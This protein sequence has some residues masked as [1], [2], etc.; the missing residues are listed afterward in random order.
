MVAVIASGHSLHPHSRFDNK[1]TG[2]AARREGRREGGWCHWLLMHPKQ[3][4]ETRGIPNATAPSLRR[5]H[6]S[7]NL[8]AYHTPP[9]CFPLSCCVAKSCGW[10][11]K[12]F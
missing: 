4:D 2:A 6:I 1:K 3:G 12:T 7:L 9:S 8:S 11:S 10:H 5:E